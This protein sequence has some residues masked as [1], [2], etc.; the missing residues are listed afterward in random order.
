M[1][2]VDRGTPWARVDLTAAGM[3]AP[4]AD[5]SDRTQCHD[6]LVYASAAWR[7]QGFLYWEQLRGIGQFLD[8]ALANL[9]DAVESAA[10]ESD[11]E[12]AAAEFDVTDAY[13]AAT[14]EVQVLFGVPLSQARALVGQA[15]AASERLPRTAEL[16]RDGQLSPDATVRDLDLD[17]FGA[18]DVPPET[19]ILIE[20]T[21]QPADPY[22]PT[23]ALDVL[24]RA[25]FQTCSVPG[26]D[27]P[28]WNCELDH[29]DEYDHACPATGG[30]T[31]LCNLGPTCVLHH[32]IKTHAG[33]PDPAEGFLDPSSARR[34]RLRH[35][36]RTS[37]Q[38]IDDQWIDDHGTVWTSITTPH[39]LTVDTPA[40][41]QWMFPQ[42]AGIRCLHQRPTTPPPAPPDP[43]PHHD[44]SRGGLHTATAHKHAWRRAERARLRRQRERAERDPPPF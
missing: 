1:V 3:V 33:T 34:R 29:V 31:C 13:T 42:L 15:I 10:V 39:G 2:H 36:L 22:R 12:C 25:L 37:D 11:S 38:W 14:T 5:D 44:P 17:Q 40:P 23:T 41:G 43:N 28:A 19:P 4:D 32:Q 18:P 8:I 9:H 21:A 26:C 7:G 27:R 30:P 24:V 16:L 35:P 6:W 20:R